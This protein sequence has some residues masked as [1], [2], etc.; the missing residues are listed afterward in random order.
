MRPRIA[1]GGFPHGTNIFAATRNVNTGICGFIEAGQAA[2]WDLAPTIWAAASPSAH[3]TEDAYERIAARIIDAVRGAGHLD[4]V[5]MDPHGAM[6]REHLDD[7]EGEILARKRGG[8]DGAVSARLS[9]GGFPRLRAA[10]IR[11]AR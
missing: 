10:S 6:V 3:V 8:A 11:P 7:G 1:I 4:A 5:R 9:G 2:S